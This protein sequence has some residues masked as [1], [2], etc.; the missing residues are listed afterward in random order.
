MTPEDMYNKDNNENYHFN[1]KNY[2]YN[3]MDAMFEELLKPHNLIQQF[4]T[5]R[6]FK[7][8]CE[9]GLI[10]DNEEMLKAFEKCEFYNYCIIIRDVINAKKGVDLIKEALDKLAEISGEKAKS[11]AVAKV[12]E[13]KEKEVLISKE[14]I[15]IMIAKLQRAIGVAINSHKKG[16]LVRLETF[17]KMLANGNYLKEDI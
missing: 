11:E 16:L 5:E 10:E 6:D 14:D 1:G 9:T 2:G 3:E 4:E 8:W 7:L 12:Q 17:E 13:E 15:E